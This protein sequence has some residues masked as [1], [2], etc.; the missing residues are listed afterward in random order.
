MQSEKR[1]PL[2]L[3][4]QWRLYWWWVQWPVAPADTTVLSNEL[5]ANIKVEGATVENVQNTNSQIGT[6]H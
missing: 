2:V 5:E 4:L 3:A 6:N 1:F